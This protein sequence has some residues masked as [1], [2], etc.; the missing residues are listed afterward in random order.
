MS[1]QV[2]GK[3]DVETHEGHASQGQTTLGGKW[4]KTRNR[5]FF[6]FLKLAWLHQH[7]DLDKHCLQNTKLSLLMLPTPTSYLHDPYPMKS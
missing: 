1:L 4:T 2:Q 7:Y 5:F 3:A 6:I